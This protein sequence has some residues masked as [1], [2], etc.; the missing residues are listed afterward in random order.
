MQVETDDFMLSL[1][2]D[3]VNSNGPTE[4]ITTHEEV[5][6]LPPDLVNADVSELVIWPFM[7]N[8]YVIGFSQFNVCIP[9]K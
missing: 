5:T 1:T 8:W 6:D 3:D 2:S 9:G 7:L 4:E